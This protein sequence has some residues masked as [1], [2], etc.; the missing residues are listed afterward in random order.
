[1]DEIKLRLA[2]LELYVTTCKGNARLFS[3]KFIEMDPVQVYMNYDNIQQELEIIH[4]LIN[5]ME[6][7]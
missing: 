5:E 2:D 4:K 7:K 3:L 1:M 6:S